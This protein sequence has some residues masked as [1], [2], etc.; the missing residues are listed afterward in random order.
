MDHAK[1]TISIQAQYGP[2]HY[3]R[4][5]AS[6]AIVPPNGGINHLLHFFFGHGRGM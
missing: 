1:E 6:I 4:N 5:D 3:H 2:A